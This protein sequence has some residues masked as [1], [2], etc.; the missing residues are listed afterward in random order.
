MFL[1]FLVAPLLLLAYFVR[2]ALFLLL[3]GL[4]LM[5]MLTVYA[6]DAIYKCLMKLN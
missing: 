3:I 5:A 1:N 4:V 2:I 6:H